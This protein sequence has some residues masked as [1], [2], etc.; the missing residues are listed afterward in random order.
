MTSW[1]PERSSILSALLNEVV[2][3]PEVVAL[4]QD[5]CRIWDCLVTKL[6]KNKTIYY[7]GSK[8]EGLDLPG[9]DEDFMIERN[10]WLQIKVIQFLDEIPT[11]SPYS[12]LLMSTENV[13]PG[14]ALLKH[15]NQNLYD[16]MLFLT[17]HSMSDSLYLSSDLTVECYLSKLSMSNK[18]VTLTR[19]GPSIEIQSPYGEFY[20]QEGSDYVLS[21][22]CD[23]WPIQA[24]E[25]TQR[26]RHFGWP[27]S[28]DISTIITFGCHLVPV[29]H[30]HSDTKLMEWRIS[31][32]VAERT[33]VWSFNHIQ[34]QCYAV[35]KIL[36][37]EFIKVRCSPQNQVL[38]S[39]FIKTFLFW[40]Y[41]SKDLYF[42]RAD[43][44]RECIMYL[45]TEFSECLREG[46]LRH[47]FIPR[48]NL[49]S[50]KLTPEART[51]LLQLF[52]IILQSDISIL[53]ECRTLQNIWSEFLQ[54]P[55][56]KNIVLHDIKGRN[57]LMNEECIMRKIILCYP[58]IST[59]R[60]LHDHSNVISALLSLSCKTYL[61]TFLLNRCL[62]WIH[63]KSLRKQ[64]SRRFVYDLH[65]TIQ[66]DTFST[67][68]SSSKL[69]Y[70]ILLLK[71]RE[72]SSI[73]NITKEILSSIPPFVVTCNNIH[74]LTWS[75]N[76][77]KRLYVDM[78]LDSDI[79]VLQRAR[80]AW[81]FDLHITKDMADVVP[82]AI[83]IELYFSDPGLR[84]IFLSPLACAYYL[85]SLCYHNTC[86]YDSRNRALEQLIVLLV[87]N[88]D[89]LIYNTMNIAGHCLLLVG[90][91]SKA[92]DIFNVSYQLTR[93]RPP[94]HKY[95][96]AMWYLHNCF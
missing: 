17:S 24:L 15:V 66:T 58:I 56:N 37:K 84:F 52:D 63:F 38:C 5:W 28:H 49:L 4:R 89:C 81:M 64:D 55:E 2:G 7:T 9:S 14:F 73:L 77:A 96:S 61:K 71:N 18:P 47:Y 10:D 95:N 50:V 1:T 41:E 83:Q 26:P 29:G 39:Y 36:L 69:W 16:P 25:W 35:M 59:V 72:F 45:L 76:E 67:D 48:F 23:F 8:A 90:E 86:H 78:F 33:L 31:F 27:T 3:T 60:Q 88:P 19:Q 57:L 51:E 92:W 11:I 54:V 74:G 80:K 79:T 46:L 85:E 34:M 6:S 65:Q 22:H 12:I 62:F 53:R 87:D 21:I 20:D 13:H 43:N 91:R 75:N 40:K 30:P 68:I 82:L 93:M 70:A 42:W 94:F 32:S 44:F